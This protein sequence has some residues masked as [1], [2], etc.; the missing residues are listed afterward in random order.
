[1]HTPLWLDALALVAALGS[2]LI[3]G[4]FFAFSTFVMKALAR[5]APAEGIAA[6][7]SINVV[8]L[9]PWFLGAFMGTAL[10]SAVA[11]VAALLHWRGSVSA[12]LIAGGLFYLVGTFGVTV[13]CNVPRNE[14]LAKVARSDEQAATLWSDY[15]RSWTLWNHVR[16][17][18]ALVAAGAFTLA[19]AV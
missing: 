1:V 11:I 4:V 18:G 17:I 7:Q 16:T 12:L 14:R 13:A 10:L 5:L 19:L 6:M 9:N 15:V 8:V 3:A 2:G